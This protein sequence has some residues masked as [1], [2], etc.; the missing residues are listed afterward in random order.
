MVT[1]KRYHTAYPSIKH[2]GLI[3]FMIDQSC[4]MKELSSFDG[5][6]LA[7]LAADCLNCSI[8]ELIKMNARQT[9]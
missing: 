9:S 6:T 1:Q 5:K 3:I 7:D 2:P 4:G 8:T